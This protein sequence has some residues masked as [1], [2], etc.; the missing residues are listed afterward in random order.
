MGGTSLKKA[1]R[2]GSNSTTLSPSMGGCQRHLRHTPEPRLRTGA[3][4]RPSW[5][6]SVAFRNTRPASCPGGPPRRPAPG[7]SRLDS[8]L[9]DDKRS[10]ARQDR[11]TSRNCTS[12]AC[13]SPT[14]TSTSR[15]SLERSALPSFVPIVS[16][17]LALRSVAPRS[18]AS[19]RKASHF[20]EKDRTSQ[21]EALSLDRIHI[22]G[23][24]PFVFL[25]I[26]GS[27]SPEPLWVQI[28]GYIS[29]GYT[30]LDG[31]IH[32]FGDISFAR[33]L[34]IISQFSAPQKFAIIGTCAT[35]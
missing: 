26:V 34:G 25:R 29:S 28:F 18:V 31:L 20:M 10:R 16:L 2:A 3:T 1:T 12:Q 11:S 4:L 17:C 22:F 5:K 24:I 14:S 8:G 13:P 33:D 23:C 7:P 32:P 35:I 6:L 27:G 21:Q 19:L 30:S 9:L 15:P